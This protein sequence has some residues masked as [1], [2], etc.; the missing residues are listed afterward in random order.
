MCNIFLLEH[1]VYFPWN[2]YAVKV[3]IINKEKYC[4][5]CMGKKTVHVFFL[6]SDY[7]WVKERVFV[8]AAQSQCSWSIKIDL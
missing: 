2:L 7:V 8:R 3:F 6:V 5:L 4:L 1:F